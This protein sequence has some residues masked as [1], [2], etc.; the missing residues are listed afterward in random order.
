MGTTKCSICA[1]RLNK[2]LGEIS[3][4]DCSCGTAWE[5]DLKKFRIYLKENYNIQEAYYFL[6]FLHEKREELYTAIQRSGFILI[7]KEHN[8]KA[9]SKK[10]GNVDT[11]IVFE[12]MKKFVENE[13]DEN[14]KIALV[15]GDG[16]YKKITDYL[17]KKDRLKKIFFPNSYFASALYKEYGNEYCVH[18]DR[19]DLKKYLI[20]IK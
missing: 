4:S 17:I 16:D 12:I 3:L 8:N 2:D 11:D 6:G 1:K 5:I 19:E 15:S 9:L 14:S 7:F 13:I 18:L 10:K 20:K